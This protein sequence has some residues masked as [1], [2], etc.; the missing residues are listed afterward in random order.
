MPQCSPRDERRWPSAR[1]R[2]IEALNAADTLRLAV[3]V[4]S[5]LEADTGEALPICVQAD[6]TATMAAP[7][8]G[9]AANP[10]ACGQVVE[11]DIGL[12]AALHER[13]LA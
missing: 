8:R 11:V 3:D 9:F 12:P 7:K 5:G 10:R 2:T 6:V 13:F 1:L 4:P